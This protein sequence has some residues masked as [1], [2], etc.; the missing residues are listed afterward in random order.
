MSARLASVCVAAV[1][2]L[3]GSS[4]GAQQIVD[5]S[6]VPRLR[7]APAFPSGRGPIVFVDE[8][9]D[10]FHTTGGRY[11]PF[12]RLLETDGFVVRGSTARFDSAALARARVLVIANAVAQRNKASADWRLP[13]YSAFESSEIAAVV[14]WVRRGGSLL[15]IADHLPFAGA[16]DSLASAF[17]VFFANG[18]AIP[19][20]GPDPRTGDYSIVFRRGAG[21]VRHRIVDGRSAR[22]RVDSVVS[23]TGSAFR[24]GASVDRPAELL[25]L[26]ARTRVRLPVVAWAF[27]DSTPEMRG[28]DMLQGAVFRLGRGRVAVFGEAAMFSAQIKGPQR[29]PMGMN[30]PEASENS[31]FV[32]NVMH[33]LSGSIPDRSP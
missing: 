7:D 17:G 16:A 8:A 5:S 22:E 14:G 3:A 28:D 15:L 1:A 9:H 18:F 10:N 11:R 6:Y 33:W 12:V 21:L 31:Q 13:S 19:P 30:A 2:L 32:L 4:L 29:V 26:P 20:S 27:S 23:F 24:L 25:R